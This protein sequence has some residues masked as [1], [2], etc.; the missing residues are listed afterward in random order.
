MRFLDA[1]AVAALGP[2]A[3]VRAITDALRGGLDPATDP[4][5][6]AVALSHGQ[7]LLMPSETP[8]AAGV[9][10]ATVAPGNPARGLPRVQAAYLLFD[11]ET[12]ALRAV[13]PQV[14][15]MAHRTG[16]HVFTVDPHDPLVPGFVLR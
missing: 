14:T 12:L 11:G 8:A 3:A 5:R 9:K 13:V 7:F 6:T 15:G 1:A 4:P 16:E 2:A 10:V